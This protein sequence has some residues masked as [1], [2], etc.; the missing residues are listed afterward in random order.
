MPAHHETVMVTDEAEP[1]GELMSVDVGQTAEVGLVVDQ[2]AEEVEQQHR[3]TG[4]GWVI[5]RR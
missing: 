1:D 2:R 5:R 4:H 3:R